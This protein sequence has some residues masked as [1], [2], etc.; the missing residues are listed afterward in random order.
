ML[1][2][3]FVLLMA[4]LAAH[5]S[6]QAPAAA[7]SP[8]PVALLAAA[9]TASGGAAWD[10]MRSQYSQVKLAAANLEGAVE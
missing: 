5:A 4:L 6:A 9:K 3:L 7:R 10:A 2:S 8:D 1:R